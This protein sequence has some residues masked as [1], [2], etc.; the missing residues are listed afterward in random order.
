VQLKHLRLANQLDAYAHYTE[1]IQTAA[2]IG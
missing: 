2:T 1:E